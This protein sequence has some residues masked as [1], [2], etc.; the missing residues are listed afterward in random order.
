MEFMN[1]F[2]S[3]I[4][5]IISILPDGSIGLSKNATMSLN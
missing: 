1:F 5:D 3:D 2:M 4:V